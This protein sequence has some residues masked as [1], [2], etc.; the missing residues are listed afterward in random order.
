MAS[1]TIRNLEDDVKTRLR[2]RA[3]GHGNSMEE[4]ARLILA[5]AGSARGS[6][7]ERARHRDSRA[8]QAVRRR[9]TGLA[10]APSGA[11]AAAVRLRRSWSGGRARHERRLG[12]DAGRALAA[13]WLS[14]LTASTRGIS[15]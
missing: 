3:A 12:V 11:R 1:I 9:G 6:A 2:Q 13:M 15:S 4:E 14:G 10:A 8:V 7:A 5:E